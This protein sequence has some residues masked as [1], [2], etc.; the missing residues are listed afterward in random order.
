MNRASSGRLE[1]WP[2]DF[3]H[4][5]DGT[6]RFRSNNDTLRVKKISN[7]RSFAEKLRV[8]HNVKIQAINV[9][10]REMLPETFR[11]L[12]RNGALFNDQA[13]SIRCRGNRARDG[14][15]CAEIRFTVLQWRSANTD[16]DCASLLDGFHRR[17][18]LQAA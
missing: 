8:R 9:V 2:V 12:H 5:R 15:N 13:I 3:L 14:L 17:N 10:N 18:E 4:H 6:R 11:G 16:E 7:R 1:N